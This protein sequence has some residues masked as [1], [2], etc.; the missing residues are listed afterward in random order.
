MSQFSYC[1]ALMFAL[2]VFNAEVQREYISTLSYNHT[3][4]V[5]P[6]PNHGTTLPL[7]F[8]L[9]FTLSLFSC[10]ECLMFIIYICVISQLFQRFL[11]LSKIFY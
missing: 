6:G 11:I 2:C 10:F 8:P 7:P 1:I 4:T 9:R 3:H 5:G